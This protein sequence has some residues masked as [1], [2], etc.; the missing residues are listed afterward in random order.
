M[1]QYSTCMPLLTATTPATFP[2]QTERLSWGRHPLTTGSCA[3]ALLGAW[4]TSCTS[5][6]FPLLNP[7]P[8]LNRLSHEKHAFTGRCCLW[9][10]HFGWSSQFHWNETER[11]ANIKGRDHNYLFYCVVF[12]CLCPCFSLCIMRIL[13]AGT[14]SWCHYIWPRINNPIHYLPN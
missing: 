12:V 1:L 6:Q 14:M 4:R 10:C 3:H 13:R 2:L 5:G 7:K 8:P 9:V 11:V